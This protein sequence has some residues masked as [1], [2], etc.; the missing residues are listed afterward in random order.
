MNEFPIR[1][2][3]GAADAPTGSWRPTVLFTDI[4]GSTEQAERLGDERWR[5]VLDTHDRTTPR[6]VERFGGQLVKLMGDGAMATF[7]GPGRATLCALARRDELHE[8]GADIPAGVHTGEIQL[9]HGDIAGLTVRVGARVMSQAAAGE[10]L[11]SETAKDL[12][13]G[14]GLRRRPGGSGTRALKGVGGER[15]LYAAATA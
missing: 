11:V 10:V 8:I 7:D 5:T 3:L 15:R 1:L 12:M 13:P 14:S 2:L 4:V 9:R 6:C